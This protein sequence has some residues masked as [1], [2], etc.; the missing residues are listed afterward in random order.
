MSEKKQTIITCDRCGV[1]DIVEDDSSEKYEGE[2]SNGVAITSGDYGSDAVDNFDLCA[3]CA[4]EFAAFM[5]K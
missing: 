4:D 3:T 2:F 1:R 5:R